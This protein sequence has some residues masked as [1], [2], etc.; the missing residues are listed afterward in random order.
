MRKMLV[1]MAKDV[2]VLLIKL[3]DRLHNMRT[4][5]SL[6]EAKQQR[7]AQE[8][9]DIYAPLAH[10]LGVQDVKWQLEDLAFA[11][12]YPKRYVEIEAMVL[13]ARGGARGVPRGGARARCAP[14]SISCR[15]TP[16]CAA[17]RSTTGRSTR[18]WSC[19]ARSSTR[20]TTSS[21]C[22]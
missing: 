16:R 12:L 8:T 4:I 20:S 18:R 1:A 19:A 22:A 21:A 15:S 7:I 14:G 11:V 3:A 13:A 5:A 10:R 17:G 6:P 2:R 9:L